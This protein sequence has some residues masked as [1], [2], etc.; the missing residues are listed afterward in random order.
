VFTLIPTISASGKL[1]PMQAVYF[2]KGGGS[3][4]NV[5]ASS[6]A[7][8]MHL[9]FKLKLSK[10]GTY[11]STQQTM[12]ELVDKIV[13]PYFDRTKAE[14]GLPPTQCSLWTIDCWSVHKSEEFHS[15][16]KTTHPTIIISFVPGGCTG[17]WQPLNVGIQRVLKQSMR[18]SAHK[19]IV[20]K[21][22]AQLNS[23]TPAALLKLDTMLGTLRNCL[24]GW[25]VKAFEDINRPDL[26]L[27]VSFLLSAVSL[28]SLIQNIF[29]GLRDV[30]SW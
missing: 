10:L 30:L 9:R 18:H 1:L 6:Y 25:V 24:L 19:D 16:M 5:K 3:L 27:K 20:A 2:G 4:P 8:A 13:A 17:L 11:W 28:M 14:L 15:W 29:T 21:T 12:W 23:G 7:E 26:I 22:V